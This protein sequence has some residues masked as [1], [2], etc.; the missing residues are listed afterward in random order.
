MIAA[1]AAGGR[2]DE[3]FA[4][5]IGTEI[6]ALAPFGG[7]TLLDVSID[8]ARGAGARRIVLVGDV[9][10]RAHAGD[11]V[12]DVLDASPDGRE[13]LVAALRAAEPHEALLFLASD[14]PFARAEDVAAFVA[15]ASGSDVALPLATAAAYDAAF[16]GAAPH[17]TR[18]GRERVANGSVAYFAPGAARRA[19]GVAGRLFEARKSLWGMASLLGPA[20]LVRFALG[21]LR[22]ADVERRANAHFGLD[23][24]AVRDAAPGLC[25]DVDTLDDYRYAL[26]RAAR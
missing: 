8:A 17:V 14:L 11:R 19:E 12:D 4:R 15:A 13:N 22:V 3:S 9:T 18:V 20:L 21:A 2:A 24:R 1:I 25:Y 6:K 5:A 16:P 23:A 26:A 7:A 10:V